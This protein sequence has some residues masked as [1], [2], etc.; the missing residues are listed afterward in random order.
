MQTYPSPLRFTTKD[1]LRLAALVTASFVLLFIAL[2]VT[3][4]IGWAQDAKQESAI[5]KTV[6]GKSD[7]L[8]VVTCP[9]NKPCKIIAVTSEEES[10]LAGPNMIFDTAYM[11]RP[12]DLGNAVAYFR[13]KLAETPI[14]QPESKKAEQK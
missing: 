10:A 9:D 4:G 8:P 14:T 3:G 12:L 7:K 5:S 13:K 6:P 11:G 1:V 2:I